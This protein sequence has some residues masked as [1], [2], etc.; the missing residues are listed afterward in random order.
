MPDILSGISWNFGAEPA[1][2]NS[3]VMDD[4]QPVRMLEVRKT[5][6]TGRFFI[7]I[8][9]FIS[10]YFRLN[11]VC[12]YFESRCGCP[13]ILKNTG[14]ELITV[15]CMHRVRTIEVLHS[16]WKAQPTEHVIRASL[17]L[18]NN[19]ITLT[20][21]LPIATHSRNSINNLSY[22]TTRFNDNFS[23]YHLFTK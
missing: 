4:L 16:L 2:Y 1:W 19:A 3:A 13:F 6:K 7:V 22:K 5:W 23:A 15:M 11:Q 21:L 9:H 8:S 12:K 10:S 14:M 18:K 20:L 17:V